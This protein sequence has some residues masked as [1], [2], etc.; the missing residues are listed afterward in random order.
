VREE[1]ETS[2]MAAARREPLADWRIRH[3]PVGEPTLT[4]LAIRK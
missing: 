4:L 1:P 3:K 2:L